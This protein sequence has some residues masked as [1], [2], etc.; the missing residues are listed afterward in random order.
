MIRLNNNELLVKGIENYKSITSMLD[1]FMIG[2][3]GF[4]AG[5]CF[6]NLFNKEKVKDIDIFFRS[7]EDFI[8]AVMYYEKNEDFI[9]DYKNSK[10]ESFKHKNSG[11]RIELIKSVFGT[12]KKIINDFDFTIT[13]FAYYKKY[14]PEKDIEYKIIHHKDFFEH[15]FMKRL[16]FSDKLKFTI[17]TYERMIRYI[18]YGY[19]P[20][21][22]SKLNM[23]LAIR[24]LEKFD[25]NELSKSLYDGLD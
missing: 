23:L 12:P 7:K 13:K 18:G 15:L 2:H 25:E 8:N 24:N 17:S 19:K 1:T 6:K 10:V 5:G 16:V 20:C 4:I 22:D 21:M 9:E 14:K 11:I 3:K